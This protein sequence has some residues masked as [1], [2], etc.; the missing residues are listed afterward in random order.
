MEFDRV[1]LKDVVLYL[2]VQQYWLY[3]HGLIPRLIWE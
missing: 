2:V 1:R 3:T